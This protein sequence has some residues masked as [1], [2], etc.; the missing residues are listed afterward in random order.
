MKDERVEEYLE[1][2]YKLTEDGSPA[3]TNELASE[4]NLSP[5]SVTEM[6]KK[7]QKKR[8]IKYKPYHGATLTRKGRR[9]GKRVTRRHR[10][11]ERFLHDV[12]K[13]KKKDVHEQACEMEHVISDEVEEAL[14]KFMS[15]PEE[16]PDDQKP[17]PPCDKDVVSCVECIE[18]EKKH[19]LRESELVPLVNMKNGEEGIIKFLRGG[20]G[21]VR[22]LA[23]MGLTRDTRIKVNRSAPF[24]GPI[25][26]RVRGTR[27]A[28]GRGVANRIFVQKKVAS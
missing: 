26:I 4:L 5:S 14:C 23:D 16:C 11:L 28:L 22:R 21:M 7:L 25:E 13:I 9:E 12:L 10:I 19:R 2:L 1:A 3:K 6:L 20:R 27:L 15:H 18:E 24:R 17:I 8:F